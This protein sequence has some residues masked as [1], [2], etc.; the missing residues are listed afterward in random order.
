MA[1]TLSWRDHLGTAGAR[2]GFFRNRYRVVPGLYGVGAPQPDAPVLVTANYKLSFDALRREL[3][4]LPPNRRDAFR[5][6]LLEQDA[7]GRA[8]LLDAA[9]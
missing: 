8:A 9:P 4:R 2:S 1:A 6:R 7:Q 5:V 3:R